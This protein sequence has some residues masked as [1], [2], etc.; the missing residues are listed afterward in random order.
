MRKL[1]EG[2]A[3]EIASGT[4]TT[5][6]LVQPDLCEAPLLSTLTRRR[7]KLII[8]IVGKASGVSFASVPRETTALFGGGWAGACTGKGGVACCSST[9][10]DDLAHA[11]KILKEGFFAM[12]IPYTD[13]SNC[14]MVIDF[15]VSCICLCYSQECQLKRGVKKEEACIHI[16]NA[17]EETS[18][19][20]S[21]HYHTCTCKCLEDTGRSMWTCWWTTG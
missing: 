19:V 14:A 8:G 1:V 16:C 13:N 3:G 9:S 17:L 4:P 7:L 12:D 11:H 21:S 18:V 2:G 20:T 15:H 5:G 6:T 10:L